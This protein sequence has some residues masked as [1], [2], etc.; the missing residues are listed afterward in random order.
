MDVLT[1]AF[2]VVFPLLAL[3]TIG[4]T[5]REL[6]VV[7]EDFLRKL[8]TLMFK[9]CLPCVMFN[10]IY[11]SDFR[12][13]FSLKL[14]L[15]AVVMA[16]GIFFFT[17]AFVER[18][19][20]DRKRRGVMV[21][22]VFRSNFILFGI[23]V[24]QTIYGAD[25]LSVMAIVV[26]IIV[27]LFNGF[28]VFLLEYYSGKSCNFKKIGKGIVKNPIIVAAMLGFASQLV[29]LHVPALL[30]SV[31]EDLADVATP[32]ALTAL[33]GTFYFDRIHDAWKQ[34]WV[35]VAG[36][37]I[38]APLICMPI[39]V[40][41]GFR[42]IELVSLFC[43]VASPTAVSSYTMAQTYD[44]DYQLAGQIVVMSSICAIGTIFVWVTILGTMGWI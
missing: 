23:P 37:L 28:C 2:S 24:A 33:G 30:Y 41:M 29:G 27:P 10:S 25:A 11:S 9:L 17:M 35:T 32:M 18:Y 39:A 6:R 5:L 40:A 3:M 4:Y 1:L 8:N 31:V 16:L 22:G 34:L 43:M 21:Q 13:D 42:N 14:V 26:S 38:L 12:Q 7:D 20:P 15:T 19:E 44:A 36:K